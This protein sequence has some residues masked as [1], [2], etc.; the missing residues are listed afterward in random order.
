MKRRNTCFIQTDY[1]FLDGNGLPRE[2]LFISDKLHLN[3]DGYRIW[4]AIIKDSIT[5]VKQTSD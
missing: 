2:E 1:A 5:K 4:S 3:G